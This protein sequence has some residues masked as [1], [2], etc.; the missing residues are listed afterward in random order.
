MCPGARRGSRLGGGVDRGGRGGRVKSEQ[1]VS[2]GGGDMFADGEFAVKLHLALCGVDVYVDF[3]G[4]DFQEEAADGV[5]TLH[6]G[7]VVALEQGEVDGAIIDGTAVHEDVLILSGRAGNSRCADQ[8]PEPEESGI[9]GGGRFVKRFRIDVGDRF[10]GRGVVDDEERGF[11]ARERAHPF[12]QL[13][14]L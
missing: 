12:L 3:G 2:D 9:G 10:E 6:E 14:E 8:S 1:A 13:A 4:I 7:S 11:G 5:A